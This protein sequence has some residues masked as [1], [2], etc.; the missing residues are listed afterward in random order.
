MKA[1]LS[2][3]TPEEIVLVDDLVTKGA[4]IA[5]AAA[6]LMEAYPGVSI[7]AFAISRT[8]WEFDRLEDPH[9]G[10]VVVAFDGSKSWRRDEA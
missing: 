6:R 4:T 9:V 5:G 3:I 1:S 7:R 8:R 2:L 10:E